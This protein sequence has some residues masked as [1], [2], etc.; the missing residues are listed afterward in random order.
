MSEIKMLKVP[1]IYKEEAISF[2]NKEAKKN[3]YKIGGQEWKKSCEDFI[4]EALPRITMGRN[5]VDKNL[6]A[7]SIGIFTGEILERFKEHTPDNEREK[8]IKEF[9]NCFTNLIDWYFKHLVD[10]NSYYKTGATKPEDMPSAIQNLY[11]RYYIAALLRC[12][13][14]EIYSLDPISIAKGV[15]S[16]GGFNDIRSFPDAKKFYIIFIKSVEKSLRKA[17]QKI[18]L[19]P[20]FTNQL[21]FDVE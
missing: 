4:A 18:K 11:M 19:A 5:P 20:A 6:K 15:R 2:A 17:L 8:A 21:E 13:I 1:Q 3:G 10:K 7:A 12:F 9:K 16:I 14:R